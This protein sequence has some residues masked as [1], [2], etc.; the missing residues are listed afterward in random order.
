MSG[1]YFWNNDT[2]ATAALSSLEATCTD[3][4]V[5]LT[6]RLSCVQSV[7]TQNLMFMFIR[8]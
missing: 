5:V 2:V 3:H 6:A 7:R 4:G 1:H 8:C